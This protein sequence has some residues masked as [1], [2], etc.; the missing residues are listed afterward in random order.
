ML[1]CLFFLLLTHSFAWCSSTDQVRSPDI[2]Q[3][4]STKKMNFP[5]SYFLLLAQNVNVGLAS[6][7]SCTSSRGKSINHFSTIKYYCFAQRH[8]L[9]LYSG[10]WRRKKLLICLD[11]FPSLS[12]SL[13]HLYIFSSVISPT[14]LFSSHFNSMFMCLSFSS[15]S[16]STFVVGSFSNLLQV[17]SLN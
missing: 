7:K 16:G 1:C 9:I 8:V 15:F 14:T 11:Y 13:S 5:F 4:K 10:I 3:V 12:L 17:E 2:A 6:L